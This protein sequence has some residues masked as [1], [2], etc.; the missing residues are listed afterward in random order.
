MEQNIS[1]IVLKQKDY[2][3]SDIVLT[4]LSETGTLDLLAKGL[5]KIGAKNQAACQ[6]FVRSEFIVAYPSESARGVITTA[7]IIDNFRL[8][9][10]L[11]A[12]AIM[13][14]VGDVIDRH[15]PKDDLYYDVLALL[16]S[17]SKAENYW[18]DFCW[19]IKRWIEKSGITP[20][21][22]KCYNCE[23]SM[24][25]ALSLSGGFVCERCFSHYDLHY[26]KEQLQ[27]FR[28]L[29]KAKAGNKESLRTMDYDWQLV[30]L[31]MRYYL[32]HQP[33]ELKSWQFLTQLFVLDT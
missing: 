4:V 23:S 1:G 21:V 6:L 26:T 8:N 33:M 20:Q 31:L 18:L 24:I 29:F 32:Y 19:I 16:V 27:L 17:L 5:K 7:S 11:E 14:V 15:F 28:Y 25:V 12:I 10:D 30:Q 13:T 2:R 3:E 9:S 22:D